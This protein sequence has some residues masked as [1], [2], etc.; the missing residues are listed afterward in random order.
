MKK[1]VVSVRG[2]LLT[3][4]KSPPLFGGTNLKRT[5]E[6]QDPLQID[7][8]TRLLQTFKEHWRWESCKMSLENN[9]L[10]EA[11]GNLFWLSMDSPT[12]DGESLPA[13]TITY[14]KVAA[15]RKLWCDDKFLRSSEDKSKR[16]YIID[17]CISTAVTSIV[18][19]PTK[20]SVGF[21]SS[22]CL[23]S[24]A[25]LCGWYSVVDD[26]LRVRETRKVM[27]LY[28]AALSFPLRLHCAPSRKQ[29][30]L[31]SITYA[32]SYV[33]AGSVATSPVS[34]FDFT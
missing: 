2:R 23:S 1:L 17:A 34:F 6:Q 28:E 18:D 8:I 21:A 32:E 15:G 9:G 29:I 11:A 25:V 30:C 22:P 5:L 12:W 24:R 4:L 31:D 26:A 20:P 13:T 33:Y 7:R 19:V 10:Y 27:K 16:Y 14:E 3:L